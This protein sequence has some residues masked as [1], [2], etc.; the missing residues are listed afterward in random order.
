MTTVDPT[1]ASAATDPTANQTPGQG[2]LDRQAF[3]KLLVAQLSNQDPLEPMQGTEFVT[4]LAQFSQVE[5]AIAQSSK[6]DVLSVQ[7]TG[8]A[9]NEAS[10]LVGK[11]VTVK[12]NSLNF[13]GSTPTSSQV[14]L[15][16][17]ATTTTVNVRDST[18]KIVRTLDLG[19]KPAGPTNVIWDGKGDAGQVMPAGTYT[20]DVT[21]TDA[22]GGAVGVEQQ[23]T[24]VVTQVAF[25]KG[26]PELVLD[27]GERVPV[28]DLISV[29]AAPGS[30]TTTSG[31]PTTLTSPSS[32][33]IQQFL[34]SLQ[35]G[36]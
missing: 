30:Q 26:Y 32:Q 31:T 20:F 13:D 15:D 29:G 19:A 10:A 34:A 17:A 33:A 5:Q 27:S 11:T 16:G 4:Q 21:A 6:L 12:G 24:G 23:S 3:L 35:T 18:G 7:L 36:P 9:N 1:S 22:T 8:L 28:S 2:T 14:T 25:D